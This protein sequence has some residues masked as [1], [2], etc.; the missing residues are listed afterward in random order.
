[1]AAVLAAALCLGAVGLAWQQGYRLYVVHTG[2]MEPTLRPG[3]AVLDR[4]VAEP[5]V[6]GQVVTFAV[7]SGPDQ[8]VTHRV[9][10]VADGR[11]HTRGDANAT[12]DAWSLTVSQ[13]RGTMAARL[14][15]AGYVLVYLR[16]PTGLASLATTILGLALLWRVF[17]PVEPAGPGDASAADAPV[18]GAEEPLTDREGRQPLLIEGLVG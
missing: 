3:D 15:H 7:P 8:V 4:P 10:S 14:P 9:A 13:L 6:P 11:I 1:M 16:Q 5:V 17:F 18:D 12:P 2:S